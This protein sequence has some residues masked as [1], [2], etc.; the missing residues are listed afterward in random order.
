MNA[1]YVAS[2]GRAV[3]RLVAERDGVRGV[4]V[5]SAKK[6]FFAG[7]DLTEMTLA[8]PDD[9]ADVFA[10]VE[11]MKRQLRPPRDDRPAGRRRAQR[12][13]PGRRPGDR[14][15]LPPADRGG[16][17]EGAVRAARGDARA[18]AGWRWG[19]PHGTDARAAGRVDERAAA[20]S[21]DEAGAGARDRPARPAGRQPRRPRPGRAGVGARARRRR[22]GG[23]PAV[24]RRGLPDARRH[25][26]DARARAVP[27]G[28]PGQPP[29]ADQGRALHRAAGDHGRGD[30]GCPGRRRH[31]AAD[32]VPLPGRPG[33][34]PAVQGHDPGVL[35]R[36]AGDHR[37]RLAAGR[38]RAVAGVPGRRARRRHDGR[39]HRVLDAPRPASTWCSRTPTSRVP[40]RAR[41]TRSPCWTRRSV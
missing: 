4:V 3:D 14:A 37:R 32:R 29:Q 27:A 40:T 36:P 9:A 12:H 28:V 41:R 22:R 24:G 23:H 31:R 15:G 10:T 20:G 8:T 2:M 18:A 16:R 19:H 6:T 7:G 17:R 1:A 30:R 33:L 5:T 11:E 39:R 35:L 13:R 25:A 21:A 34:P 38:P 26:G